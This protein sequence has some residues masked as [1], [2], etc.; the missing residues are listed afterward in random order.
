MVAM[1]GAIMP[2]PLAMAPTRDRP[3]AEGELDQRPPWAGCRWSGWRAP[4]RAPPSR[5]EARAAAA[6]PARTLSIGRCTPMTPVEATTTSAGGQ[7][8]GRRGDRAP[9]R[10]RRAGPCSP[11]AA[12]AQPAFTTTARAPPAGEVLARHE[13]RRR[14]RAVGGEDRR[15]PRSGP[16]ATSRARSRP[17]G[18]DPGR[19]RG[20][21]EPARGGDACTAAGLARRGR[22]SVDLHRLA[23]PPGCRSRVSART[24]SGRPKSRMKPSA[25]LWS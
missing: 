8:S 7:P 13:D 11:V 24:R 18:L 12:L 19:D 20:G 16:S 25:S 22:A 1:L 10:A 5:R 21:A 9:S 15:P 14:L 23:R 2:A 3:A 6:I 4:P 17:L